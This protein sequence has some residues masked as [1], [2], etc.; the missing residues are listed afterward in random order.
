MENNF[1]V[2]AIKKH[3]KTVAWNTSTIN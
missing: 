3:D 1:K 2:A